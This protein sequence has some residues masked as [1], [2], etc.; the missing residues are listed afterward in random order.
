MITIHL[1]QF[2][3]RY[4]VNNEPDVIERLLTSAA[5]IDYPKSCFEIQILDDSDDETIAEID[6]VVKDLQ[7]DG[8]SLSVLRRSDRSDYK[9]GALAVG[10]TKAQGEYLAI[11]DADFIIP[12]N[13]LKRTI[14]LLDPHSDVACVQ[15]RWAH[16][17]RRQNILTRGISLGID[18]HFAI[19]QGA[20]CYNGLFM[21][22]NGTAGIWRK[23]AIIAGGGW[24]GQTLTEDLDLSYRVQLAGYRMRYD[25]DLESPAEIPST[26]LAFKTQQHRW[27][28]GSIETAI[29]LLPR[30]MKDKNVSII[31]KAES[32]LHMTHYMVSLFM[33]LHALVT[34]PFLSFVPIRD[35]GPF[36]Y[37]LWGFI[38]LSSCAPFIMYLASGITVGRPFKSILYFPLLLIIGAGVCINNF[39]AVMEA[40]IGKR[41]EFVRTPKSGSTDSAKRKSRYFGT[42]GITLGILELILGDL[43]SI[44]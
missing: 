27:A 24:S 21:N 35:F 8:Y 16:T 31:H 22:F 4:T 11:F 7:T 30:I 29:K 26:I 10:T 36:F 43:A 25:L 33:L 18:G 14:A 12:P 34:L 3:Y 13:F 42:S 41:S 20:R 15:S 19:E 38:I 17:N 23:G 40:F 1:S 32:I 28:K 39:I 5:S 37:P 44:F 9:A 6:R 2:N